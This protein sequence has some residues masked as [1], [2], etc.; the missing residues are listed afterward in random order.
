MN[1]SLF[2]NNFSSELIE[3]SLLMNHLW[4]S[5]DVSDLSFEAMHLF[6]QFSDF[7]N[8]MLPLYFFILGQFLLVFSDLGI[9]LLDLQLSMTHQN[10]ILYCLPSLTKF[11]NSVDGFLLS[12]D[13]LLFNALVDLR[14]PRVNAFDLLF[15]FSDVLSLVL[16][17]SGVLDHL[18]SMLHFVF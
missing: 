1:P 15:D 5:L 16:D 17:N 4:V 10:I 13:S 9:D 2:A 8:G 7:T 12:Q 3:L 11:L 18:D 14:Q 6:C